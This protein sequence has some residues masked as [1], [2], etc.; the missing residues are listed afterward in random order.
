MLI[1]MLL[2]Y[3]YPNGVYPGGSGR[4][5]P[6]LSQPNKAGWPAQKFRN[7]GKTIS[8]KYM[9]NCPVYNSSLVN[10]LSLKCI[11]N[12]LS[13]KS[14]VN[15]LSL[16]CTVYYLSLECTFYYFS[17]KS[18]DNLEVKVDNFNLKSTVN[19]KYPV[20][21]FRLEVGSCVFQSEK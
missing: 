13:L 4:H 20:N 15:Y 18:I 11:V 10:F 5:H 9:Y 3:P 21:Q 2:G 7:S 1:F 6:R 17:F 12:Y 8:R 19:F 16:K 14:I